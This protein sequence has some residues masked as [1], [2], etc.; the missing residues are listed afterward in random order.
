MEY[1]SEEE[2]I[3]FTSL[4]DGFW[5]LVVA[6]IGTGMPFI[7]STGVNTILP[8]LQNELGA[9]ITQAQWIIESYALMVSSLILFGGAM[10]DKFGR[11]KIFTIG[12]IIFASCSLWCGLASSTN[13]L[14]LARAFQGVGGALLIPASLALL[15]V[16][17]DTRTRGRALGIWS[18][19]VAVTTALG[20]LIGGW[21]AEAYT[22]RYVFLIN[23]PISIVLLPVLVFMVQND[24]DLRPIKLDLI[25]AV[26]VSLALGL[27]V[28]GLIESPNM[29][30][31]DIRVIGSILTG[32][33]LGVVLIF[34]ER[35]VKD[36]LVPI[37]LFRSKTFTGVN[38]VS[39]LFWFSWNAVIFYVPFGF[40]QLHGYTAL[41][42]AISFL[43]GFVAL[44]ILA[45]LSGELIN[46]FGV[47]ILLIIGI[48][49]VSI[50]FYLFSLPGLDTEYRRDWLL[51][52][53]F[54]GGGVG[55]SSSPMISAVVGSHDKMYSGL[56]SG[57]NNA[58]GR[59]AGLLGIAII[60]LV[61]IN[62]F[63]F[64]FDKHLADLALDSGTLE[65]LKSE[66]IRFTAAR[67]P[68]WLDSETISLIQ[69]SLK[70]SFHTTF[71]YVMK[72]CAAI[73]F[74]G[75]IFSYLLIDDSKIK[76]D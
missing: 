53:L 43:P 51:P 44:L 15:S 40:I 56:V 66:R 65:V 71:V 29:G 37:E 72:L 32:L 59:I 18:A 58:V 8:I 68:E 38:I 25:G 12:L 22:W 13:E 34:Y 4:K 42:L 50:G 2:F 6:I 47:K 54:M 1:P 5:V 64:N 61:G 33:I 63:N 26:L 48:L 76:L 60:G 9:K 35:T 7:D 19:F 10:G 39:F 23:I 67:I 20:P 3:P 11:K 45:P 17:F 46:R 27:F 28:F 21:L 31:T 62:L 24:R 14:I 55:L 16:S 36:P 74:L 49:M 52:I 70:E 30:Y 73:C 75:S 41:E 57:I 69:L